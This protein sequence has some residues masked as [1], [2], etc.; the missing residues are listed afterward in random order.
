MANL[1]VIDRGFDA[2][3][4]LSTREKLMVGGLASAFLL[5]A[6]VLVWLLVGKKLDTLEQRNE[7]MATTL[8]EIDR[9]Q[10]DYLRSKAR[11]VAYKRQ[12][13]SNKLKLVKLMEDEAKTLGFEIEDFKETKRV[14]T[15]NYRRKR[16]RS[17]EG[18]EKK[19]VKDLVER[20]QTV[21]IRRI[22]LEQLTKFLGRLEG[23]REPVKVTRLNIHTLASDR[24]VLREVRMTVSTYRNEEVDK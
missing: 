23:R 7:T 21:T 2:F 18:G 10:D 24:Q 16:K 17:G 22:S 3:E 8:V 6:V 4:R 20:S 13:D 12:L 5:T 19:A 9:Q 1:N 11:L 15:E 14:L